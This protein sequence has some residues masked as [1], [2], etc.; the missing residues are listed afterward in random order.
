MEYA[1]VGLMSFYVMDC[2]SLAGIAGILGKKSDEKELKERSAKYG[3]KLKS[4][5]DD[6]VGIFLNKRLDNGENPIVFRLPIFT[7][8][9]QKFV[10]NSRRK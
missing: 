7:R 6:S 2:N 8:C 5:W 1:D 4:L 9:W 3:E 10:H